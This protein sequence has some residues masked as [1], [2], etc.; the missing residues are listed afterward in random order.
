MMFKEYCSELVNTAKYYDWGYK[1][2]VA[3][4]VVTI[5]IITLRKMF[6]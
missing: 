1:I 4:L 5:L 3:S 2:M 6:Q